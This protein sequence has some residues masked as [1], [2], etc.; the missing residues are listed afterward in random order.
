[1]KF[2]LVDNNLSALDELCSSLHRIS[3]ESHV[4]KIT[5]PLLSAKYICN[6]DV[7]VVFL[8]DQMRPVDGFTLL[9]VLRVQKP[10]LS[11]FVLSHTGDNEQKSLAVG[12][13][14]YFVKPVTAEM[15]RSILMIRGG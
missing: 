14:G 15:L 5:D 12:A 9:G 3:P 8:A 13:S 7:D 1:M 11:V 4:K 6:N 10:D 2:V